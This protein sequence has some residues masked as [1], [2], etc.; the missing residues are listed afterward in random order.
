ME[1]NIFIGEEILKQCSYDWQDLDGKTLTIYVVK[2]EF[3][4]NVYGK[5]VNTGKHYLISSDIK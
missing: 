2:S 1:D 4:I 3:L 5:E